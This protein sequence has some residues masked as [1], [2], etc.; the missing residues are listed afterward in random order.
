M[1][2]EAKINLKQRLAYNYLRDGIHKFIAY[3]GAGGG[4]KSWL[5]CEWL[6]QCCHYL[7]GTRWFVGRNNLKDSRESV[8][9]TF[10][11][12]AK[13]HGFHAYKQ[14]SDGFVFNNGSEIIF[15]DLTYYPMKDPMYER[16]GSKEYTGGWIEEAGQVHYLAFE[17]LKTRV[18]RHLNDVYGIPSKILVTCNPKKNWLYTTFYRPWKEH[19]LEREYAFIP[20]LVQDNPWATEDY[21]EMLRSTKDEVTKQRLFFGNW[22]Y[23]DD[24]TALCDYDAICDIF[25]NEHV[26]ATGLG[27]LSADLAMKGRDRFVTGKAVGHVCTIII[28]KEYSPGKMIETDLRNAM[29]EHRVSRSNVVADSDGLGAFLESYLTGIKEFRGGARA[30][31]DRYDNLKTQCAF[32]LAELINNRDFRVICSREQEERIKAE[33]AQ[34]K[35]ASVDSDTKKKGL[36]SK[37]QM[38]AALN[39]SPDYLDMLIMLMIFEIRKPLRGAKATVTDVD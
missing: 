37:D 14:T 15:L 29:I 18:G 36:I 35:Q 17:V 4:G 8:A 38:K 13:S 28:D 34:L 6:M 16:L 32:K 27:R 39:H 23:D 3:G 25:T 11:K 12:V 5:G 22:E 9:I 31:D 2:Q 1:E 20:A 10:G 26:K 30:L 7:P 24:P 19:K 33:L 21:I